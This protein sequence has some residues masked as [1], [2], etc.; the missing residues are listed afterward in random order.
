MEFGD[1][2]KYFTEIEVLCQN[3]EIKKGYV[4]DVTSIINK[5]FTNKFLKI[6]KNDFRSQ[7]S[8]LIKQNIISKNSS[9]DN[10]EQ[11]LETMF[12]ILKSENK[13]EL[14]LPQEQCGDEIINN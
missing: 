5:R 13:T 12:K 3:I 14:D 9:Q 1:F 8:H 11:H 4:K 6:I 2:C 7:L 10:E